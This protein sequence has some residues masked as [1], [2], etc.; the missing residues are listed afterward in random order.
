MICEM[1]MNSIVQL[2]LVNRLGKYADYVLTIQRK[3]WTTGT[4]FNVDNGSSCVVGHLLREFTDHDMETI[5][6][7]RGLIVET[8]LGLNHKEL[9]DLI[10]IN[11]SYG[12]KPRM[13]FADIMSEIHDYLESIGK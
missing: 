9:Q 11:D 8:E 13:T 3:E 12:S 1:R 4:Y 5:R 6:T 7:M 2:Y 10:T